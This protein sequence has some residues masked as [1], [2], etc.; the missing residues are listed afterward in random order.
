MT[1][2]PPPNP[3]LIELAQPEELSKVLK[4]DQYDCLACRLTGKSMLRI[5]IGSYFF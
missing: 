1:G 5:T 2:K 4:D 3:A